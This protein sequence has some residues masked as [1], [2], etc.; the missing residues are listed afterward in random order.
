ML[1]CE[2]SMCGDVLLYQQKKY[3]FR[4]GWG[5]VVRLFLGVSSSLRRPP[6]Q[7]H[8]YVLLQTCQRPRNASSQTASEALSYRNERFRKP[9]NTFV[10]SE[11]K[12][13]PP[14]PLF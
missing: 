6:L 4:V 2:V 8:M 11:F 1:Y 12:A 14:G 10:C 5:G 9:R 13:R 7:T 3:V